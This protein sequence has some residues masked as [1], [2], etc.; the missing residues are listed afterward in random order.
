[1]VT[2]A[3]GHPATV[4]LLGGSSEIG[5]AVAAGLVARG[6]QTVVLAGRDRDRLQAAAGS[7]Q[8]AGAQVHIVD[9][10]ADQPDTH[11]AVV[12][13]VVA[14]H[15]D[16][17]V[18]ILAFGVLGDQTRDERDPDAAVAVTRTNYLGAVSALTV[19]GNQLRS[20]GHGA[21]VVLSSVAGERVRRS[22][23]IYGAS[24][25]ALDG[26]ALGVGEALRG[27]G[28][29]VLV[30]RPGFV[31]T[32][33]THGQPAAPLSTTPKQV[34]AAALHALDTGA[35]IVWVP[36]ALRPVLAVLRHLPRSV[37]RRLPI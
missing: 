6:A 23:Y 4:L 19:L 33:M 16:L 13:Q 27:S 18:T 35:D 14:R 15:G 5:S 11:H 34:A 30:V 10:D 25:A 2:D 3:L 9:F 22:N 28:A 36:G 32:Q 21:I 12:Q 20:Q 29:T 37:F 8:T 24:K 1:M 7:L 31:H 17:D 26:F